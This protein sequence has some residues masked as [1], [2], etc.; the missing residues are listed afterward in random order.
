MNNFLE[1]IKDHEIEYSKN[2]IGSRLIEA[3]LPDAAPENL[4]T[5]AEA[6]MESLRPICCDEFASHVL[7][8]LLRTASSRSKLVT[9]K[10]SFNVQE[11]QSSGKR[12]SRILWFC[13]T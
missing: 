2:Q 1:E 6:F 10:L 13:R 7:E 3:L 11:S 12:T 4:K 5:F 8:A 9:F